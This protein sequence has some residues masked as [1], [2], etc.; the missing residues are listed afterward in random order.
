MR[1]EARIALTKQTL[2]W[3]KCGSSCLVIFLI[4]I[5]STPVIVLSGCW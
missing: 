4:C 5:A 3:G 1:R 2:A